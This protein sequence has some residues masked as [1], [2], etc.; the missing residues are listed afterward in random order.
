[1]LLTCAARLI[2]NH[3]LKHGIGTIVFG[4]NK[5]Q[6]QSIE[7]GTKTNQK[8]VQIPTARLKERIKELCSLYG[9]Q[10][11]ETEESYT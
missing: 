4:W 9:L 7:L 3:G 11:V 8:L 10:F 2:I 1:M 6:K 5:G